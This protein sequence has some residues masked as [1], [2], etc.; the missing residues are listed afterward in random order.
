MKESEVTGEQVC[1]TPGLIEPDSQTDE[2]AVET[3]SVPLDKEPSIAE[4]SAMSDDESDAEGLTEEA[5]AKLLRTITAPARLGFRDYF[6]Q[7]QA[8]TIVSGDIYFFTFKDIENAKR[9]LAKADQELP[10][11]DRLGKMK[12]WFS[13]LPDDIHKHFA[14]LL[15]LFNEMPWI[16]FVDVSSFIMG[17]LGIEVT[18]TV[19]LDAV[20]AEVIHTSKDSGEAS[21][22]IVRFKDSRYGSWVLEFYR[23]WFVQ[24]VPAIVQLARRPNRSIRARAALAIAEIG[25]LDFNRIV[26][27]SL[28]E[29]ATSDKSYVRAAVGYTLGK[30]AQ[31]PTSKEGVKH[32]LR[33]WAGQEQDWRL[34]WSVASAC[35]QIGFIDLDFALCE[36]NSLATSGHLRR[37]VYKAIS[38]SLI[39]LSLSGYLRDVLLTLRDWANSDDESAELIAVLSFIDLADTYADL[40]NRRSRATS[41][42]LTSNEILN[43]L[44]V[45]QEGIDEELLS[46]LTGILIHVLEKTL[47]LKQ[48]ERIFE[49]LGS[50][51]GQASDSVDAQEAIQRIISKMY[52]VLDRRGKRH[53]RHY[54]GKHWGRDKRNILVADLAS[55]ILG[56]LERPA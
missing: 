44:I 16:D 4:M 11:R 27:P 14:L 36:L 48:A 47:A 40:A 7:P 1:Q 3:T 21:T 46:A 39:V 31:D 17:S 55:A 19:D 13:E 49:I 20:K 22:A 12:Q 43:L 18:T 51:L 10:S 9:L 15:G 52:A 8:D 53:L 34:K 5:A 37:G 24:W 23:P 38:Y 50:W 28:T 45:P 33:S 54:L 26:K 6:E 41:K 29:L 56:N 30:L 32:L 42:H 25:K 35:K 2:D